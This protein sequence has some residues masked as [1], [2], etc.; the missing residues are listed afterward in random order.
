MT[1]FA[2]TLLFAAA[3]AAP[4]LPA[5]AAEVPASATVRHADQ[6]LQWC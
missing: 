5:A 6:V 4:V 1:R 2:P 3:L